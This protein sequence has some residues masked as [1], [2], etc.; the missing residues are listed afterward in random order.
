MDDPPF[1]VEYVCS[2]CKEITECNCKTKAKHDSSYLTP[3]EM[4]I[5]RQYRFIQLA[6]Q[7]G[8]KRDRYKQ[9]MRTKKN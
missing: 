5:V 7:R 8:E 4:A 9:E 1:S 6:N 2:I 3:E